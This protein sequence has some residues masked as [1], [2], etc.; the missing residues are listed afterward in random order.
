MLPNSKIVEVN[1]K[2]INQ[3]PPTCFLKEDNVGY[4][5]KRAWLEE[6]FKEGLKIK[7]LYLEGEKKPTGY[8]EYIPGEFAWRAVDAQGYLFIHCLWT[9]KK[10]YQGQG[11]GTLLIKEVEKEAEKQDL[12]GVATVSSEGSFMASKALFVKNGYQSVD[13]ASPSFKLMVKNRRKGPTPHFKDCQK[14]LEKVKGWQI[15]YSDQCPWV[16]R[17]IEEEK[18]LLAKKR[19][20]VTRLKTAQEV[21]NGPSIYGVFN[22]IND[23]KLLAD[24][25]ISK[26]RFLKILAREKA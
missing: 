12:V 1:L 8:V 17:F 25:Y 7:L 2:N 20:K 11:L 26:R 3:Y 14:V 13:R 9:Y 18:S 10:K 4:L 5:K 22:L 6:R 15:I 23:G 21:Q 16:A 24:H 19:I